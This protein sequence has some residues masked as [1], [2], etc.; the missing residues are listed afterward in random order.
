MS[1]SRHCAF[2]KA[3]DG[4]WYME[5][6]HH[7]HDGREDATT[8]GPFAS[9]DA[10]HAYR[11]GFVNPGGATIDDSGTEPPPTRS[12]NGSPVVSPRSAGAR[13]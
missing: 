12:P 3:T 1:C 5:L 11:R 2:Y 13:S 4:Q 6:A 9:E 7:E 10:A 8:Y